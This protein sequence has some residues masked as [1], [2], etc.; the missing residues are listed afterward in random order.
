MIFSSICVQI[1]T[2]FTKK[3]FK[4]AAVIALFY[5]LKA[6]GFFFYLLYSSETTYQFSSIQ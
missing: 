4:V 2:M 5:S 6:S 3:E 1:N